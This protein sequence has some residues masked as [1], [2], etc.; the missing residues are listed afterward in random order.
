MDFR[1]EI[2]DDVLEGLMEK[3]Q[4]QGITTY[5]F[6]ANVIRKASQPDE[7]IPEW[8]LGREDLVMLPPDPQLVELGPVS[9]EFLMSLFRG[10]SMEP[11]AVGRRLEIDI[12]ERVAR[13]AQ[14]RAEEIR[15]RYPNGDPE[16]GS[17]EDSGSEEGSGEGS[18]ED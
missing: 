1:F 13:Q 14:E 3:A 7:P 6:I 4:A 18:R 2:D 11:P 15:S 16:S 8:Q 9:R 12:T 10:G 5:E 17:G